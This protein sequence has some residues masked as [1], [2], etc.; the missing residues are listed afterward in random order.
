MKELSNII[1]TINRSISPAD[2]VIISGILATMLQY[3]LDYFRD[4]TKMLNHVL[5]LIMPFVTVMLTSL[6]AVGSPLAKY[7]V[8]FL[9]AQ[10]AYNVIEWLRANAVAHAV[11][12]N[13]IVVPETF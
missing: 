9:V 8:A 6:I 13:T 4:F 11:V 3:L 7:P 5:S 1:H 2:W 10:V 12:E